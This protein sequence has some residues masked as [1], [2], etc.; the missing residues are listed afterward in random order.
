MDSLL[1]LVIPLNVENKSRKLSPVTGYIRFL[2]LSQLVIFPDIQPFKICSKPWILHGKKVFYPTHIQNFSKPSRPGNQRHTV[3]I[4]PSFSDKI[5]L[6]YIKTMV[7]SDRYKILISYGDYWF[8]AADLLSCYKKSFMPPNLF[9][10]IMIAWNSFSV[11][12]DFPCSLWSGHSCSPSGR[13]IPNFFQ[14]NGSHFLQSGYFYVPFFPPM[15]FQSQD[16]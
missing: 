12:S 15:L 11:K 13:I 16:L 1:T 8:H 2:Q 5:R 7:F 10:E 6:I 14:N 9:I 3:L 4:L